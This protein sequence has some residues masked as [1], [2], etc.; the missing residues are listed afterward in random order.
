MS[1]IPHITIYTSKEWPYGN[2]LNMFSSRNNDV[3]SGYFC[4]VENG[5]NIMTV[6]EQVV[7]ASRSEFE[8]CSAFI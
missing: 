8:T 7:W 3:K 4:L 1:L 5:G 6:N 2:I